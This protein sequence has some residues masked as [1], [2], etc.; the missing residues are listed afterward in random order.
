MLLAKK[1]PFV[2]ERI[3]QSCKADKKNNIIPFN[4]TLIFG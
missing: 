4:N 1:E 2:K 3:S